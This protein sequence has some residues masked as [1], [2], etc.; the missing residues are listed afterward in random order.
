M[1]YILPMAI[2]NDTV[3]FIGLFFCAWKH[4]ALPVY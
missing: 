1:A 2:F 3:G 4:R